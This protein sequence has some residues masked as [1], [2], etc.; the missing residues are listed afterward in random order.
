MTRNDWVE[1]GLVVWALVISV[2]LLGIARVIGLTVRREHRATSG[3]LVLNQAVPHD[4]LAALEEHQRPM[5][6]G[7]DR[8][9]V[10]LSADCSACLTA[11]RTMAAAASD[12]SAAAR[13]LLDSTIL[14]VSGAKRRAPVF[15]A[16]GS[17]ASR[18]VIDPKA[19]K[20]AEA[21]NL[22]G[23][24]FALALRESKIMGWTELPDFQ[25]LLDFHAN[26]RP[27]VAY[28]PSDLER[29]GAEPAGTVH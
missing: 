27:T 8:Y 29:D 12:G 21:L 15:D 16:L 10:W 19:R 22:P 4:L 18:A 14:L 23:T 2:G 5:P 13:T 3:T 9:L 11:A 20:L 26:N 1:L 17:L 24:P 25:R 28:S 7:A 6:A